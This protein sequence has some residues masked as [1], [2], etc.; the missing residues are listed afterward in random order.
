MNYVNVHEAK[1]KL[2]KLIELALEGKEII[3]GKHNKP[4]V[5]LKPLSEKRMA[6]REGGQLKGKIWI[7]DDF[8]N[9]SDEIFK[10]FTGK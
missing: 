1:A 5:Q 8:D 9:S 7:A 10:L 6:K 2:S 3:I 4:L